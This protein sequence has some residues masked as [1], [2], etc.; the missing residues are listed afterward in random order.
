MG[1]LVL[2][3]CDLN[4]DRRHFLCFCFNF[5]WQGTCPLCHRTCC[6]GSK[7]VLHPAGQCW[8]SSLWLWEMG[9][10]HCGAWGWP[11]R[12]VHQF[13]VAMGWYGPPCDRLILWRLWHEHGAT[14]Q[15]NIRRQ[16]WEGG[17]LQS[18]P[19]CIVMERIGFRQI[20]LDTRSVSIILAKPHR[21][22]ASGQS[23]CLS[24]QWHGGCWQDWSPCRNVGSRLGV[25]MNDPFVPFPPSPSSHQHIYILR[26]P[27]TRV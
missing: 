26:W 24:S 16:L 1:M 7:L 14:R 10:R 23:V 5:S 25:T 20:D 22:L 18:H 13:P 21:L 27:R 8:Q 2:R 11:V 9:G 12:L 15:G 3:K 17:C 4:S 6:G 19:L